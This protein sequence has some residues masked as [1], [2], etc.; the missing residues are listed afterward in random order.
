MKWIS[1]DVF[2]HANTMALHKLPLDVKKVCK[3]SAHITV[4]L[5]KCLL[6]K[7]NFYRRIQHDIIFVR[8]ILPNWRNDCIL[9]LHENISAVW[10]FPGSSLPGFRRVTGFKAVLPRKNKGHQHFK[11]VSVIQM[12]WIGKSKMS[13][14]VDKEKHHF[15]THYIFR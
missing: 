12:P 8:R 15:K 4:S 14:A 7:N 6:S 13:N 5:H 10:H 9:K 3:A 2:F 1:T 11:D